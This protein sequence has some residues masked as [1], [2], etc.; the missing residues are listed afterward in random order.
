MK[1]SKLIYILAFALLAG[2]SQTKN[3][4]TKTV[5]NDSSQATAVK[6]ENP[7][8]LD[9]I[10]SGELD[11]DEK[12]TKEIERLSE[13]IEKNPD[14]VELYKRRGMIYFYK[15]AAI[16][17]KLD[18]TS[19][20]SKEIYKKAIADLTKVIEKNPD[21]IDTIR[22][23]AEAYISTDNPQKALS[24]AN[25]IK[26]IEPYSEISKTIKVRAYKIDKQ[27]DEAIAQMNSLIAD[28]E[29]NKKQLN[30]E[31]QLLSM[32]YM[33]RGDIYCESGDYDKCID[34]YKK[35]FSLLDTTTAM[36]GLFV[37]KFHA[38]LSTAF[39]KKKEYNNAILESKAA[40]DTAKKT[41]VAPFVYLNLGD[42][43]SGKGEHKKAVET[44]E[45]AIKLYSDY[46]KA[47]LQ[48]SKALKEMGQTEKA[49]EY[50]KKY[51]R[52]GI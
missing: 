3:E 10:V 17:T 30:K 31:Q 32:A 23:R 36:G 50:Q 19:D 8:V 22:W 52:L 51:E 45:E 24:D 14:K 40:I 16:S 33:E 20:K 13:Q 28:L 2:C 34:D 11:T 4:T 35:G 46:K 21:D 9:Q 41:P 12:K 29:K 42:A 27:Y 7:S 39:L 5:E 38:T 48:C 26:E 37:S 25:K 43:Y 49:A 44:Y 18:G 1:R 15:A 6:S 47:Y